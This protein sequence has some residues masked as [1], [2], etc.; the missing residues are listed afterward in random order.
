LF[1]NNC[2]GLPIT[3]ATAFVDYFWSLVDRNAPLDLATTIWPAIAFFPLF[4][5]A[6][7]LVKVATG[8]LVPEDVLINPLWTDT[9]LFFLSQPV[10]DLFGAPI[11]LEKLINTRPGFARDTASRLFLPAIYRK[12]VSLL[13]SIASQS[14]ISRHFPTDSGLMSAKDFSYLRLRLSCCF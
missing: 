10:A 5:A 4:L 8:L 12:A 6:K 2:I 13:G 7:V 11:F 9:G 3:D 1:A 14:R